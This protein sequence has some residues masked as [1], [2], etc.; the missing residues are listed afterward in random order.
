MTLHPPPALTGVPVLETERLR[1]RGLQASD[2]NT[3]AAF[4]ASPRAGFVGGPNGRTL[5]WRGFCS[6]TGHW[7]HRGYGVFVF[8]DKV[9]DAPLGTTGPWYPEG[10]PEPEIAWTVW[11][12]EAEGKGYAHEAATAARAYAY[13]VL[14]W[15]TAI[16]LIDPRNTRSAALARRMGCVPDGSFV[17]EQYGETIIWRHP[18]ADA[19]ADG[20]MEAYA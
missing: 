15:A 13:G 11:S 10:W 7:V 12:P 2:F 9:T 19:L 20:G 1:L 3:F 17:H 5:A 6:M 8:C 16:S 14:G 4:A 18:S